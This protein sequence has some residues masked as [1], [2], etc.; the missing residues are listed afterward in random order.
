MS[1]ASQNSSALAGNRSTER[2]DGK[3]QEQTLVAVVENEA[4]VLARVVGLFARRGYNIASL[5]VAPTQDERFSRITF[6]Y[7]GSA[8]VE[9][10]VAQVNKLINV[11]SIEAID[12]AQS[13]ERELLLA[14]V[15]AD[16]ETRSSL[17]DLTK[18]YDGKIIDVGDGV[19]TV[20]LA[21]RSVKLDEFEEAIEPLGIAALQRSGVIALPLAS[22]DS[23]T[24]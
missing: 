22:R 24:V 4:G 2:A 21:A 12:P 16:S 10:V 19:V 18:N 3:P 7:N 9:Q 1:Q 5:A 15:K 13:I 20:M 6:V 8:P 14:T 11:I 23:A 17:V